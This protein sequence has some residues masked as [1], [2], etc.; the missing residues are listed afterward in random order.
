MY[1]CILVSEYR[2]LVILE[3][4]C[5]HRIQTKHHTFS[6]SRRTITEELEVTLTILESVVEDQGTYTVK[7]TNEF[8]SVECDAELT[9]LYEA[10]SFT[11]P[12]SDQNTTLDT[13]VT[14]TVKVKGQPEPVTEWSVS[15]TV[16]TES[17]KYH[18]ER[19]EETATLTVRDVKIEDT[20]V[21]YTCRAVPL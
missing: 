15:G 8:G 6:H 21:E 12:L 17:D 4:I 10:P 9:I 18:I 20:S 11:Q 16:I 1:M 2:F 19:H 13:D 3:I 7:A 5:I 14:F